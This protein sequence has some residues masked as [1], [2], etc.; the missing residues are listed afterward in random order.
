MLAN[1]AMK[2]KFIAYMKNG[3]RWEAPWTEYEIQEINNAL[4]LFKQLDSLSHLNFPL[5][6]NG[7]VFLNPSDISAVVVQTHKS[8][9]S[10]PLFRTI[11]RHK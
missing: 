3:D 1:N 7:Q 2:V 9:W 8:F 10:L 6:K 5:K 11:R 4:K